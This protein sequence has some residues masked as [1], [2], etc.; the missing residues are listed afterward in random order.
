MI[1]PVFAASVLGEASGLINSDVVG[2][3]LTGVFSVGVIGPAVWWAAGKYYGDATR[4][5]RSKARTLEDA[6]EHAQTARQQLVEHNRQLASDRAVAD[7]KCQA[8]VK[9]LATVTAERDEAAKK[10]QLYFQA[11]SGLKKQRDQ[12]LLEMSEAKTREDALRTELKRLGV[13]LTKVIEEADAR[14]Q[15]IRRSQRRLNQ[16]LKLE[17]QLW[18]AKALQGRP[19][20]REMGWRKR[21]IISVLNLKGGV[22]KT[23][24]TAHL[25]SALARCGRRVLMVD[26]DLQGSL[27]SF[28]LPNPQVNQLAADGRLVQHFLR[29]AVD[30][31]SVKLDDFIQ[32]VVEY[33]KSGG[34]LDLVGATDSLAYAELTLT[35]KWLVQSGTR[36]SRFLLRKALHLIGLGRGYDV[37][38]L[39]CPPIVNVS[40]VNALAASDYLLVPTTLGRK[41]AE[42]VPMLLR[43]VLANEKFQHHINVHLKPVGLLA[44]RTFRAD[45]NLTGAEKDEWNQLAAECQ[46]VFG[47]PV[48]RFEAVVPQQTKD[49]RDSETQAGPPAADTALAATFDKLATELI[50][51]LP[52]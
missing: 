47:Q 33:P 37:V 25:A 34:W 43:R 45:G 40:C 19:K 20:F 41:S 51:R 27:T 26:L 35:M 11:G 38:L 28:F 16:A 42:R 50:G 13:D 12:L 31:H 6:L 10:N 17:G 4:T 39:D 14:G 18:A 21:A 29:R 7:Q 24:V 9:Q 22:G 23:T 48:N 52:K 2:K 15:A 1:D 49:I 30:H 44:N 32:P 8:A 36:D 46:E 5:A 3:A